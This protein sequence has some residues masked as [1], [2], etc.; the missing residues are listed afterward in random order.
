MTIL[1]FMQTLKHD[2]F[3]SL[4]KQK[5]Y[6][7]I[8]LFSEN[9]RAMCFFFT[10]GNKW[11]KVKYLGYNGKRAVVFQN[12][13]YYFT[14]KQKLNKCNCITSHGT[15]QFYSVA[16]FTGKNQFKLIHN[17]VKGVSARTYSINYFQPLTLE[18]W[19]ANLQQMPLN[20]CQQVPVPYKRLI[21]DKNETDKRTS[22]RQILLIIE[23]SKPTNEGG[24]RCTS[25]PANTIKA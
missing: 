4:I 13:D 25:F 14:D 20:R 15:A 19:Y 3:V 22:N 5:V 18:S 24:K 7:K 6:N 10:A 11:Y 9:L 21:Q 23:R 2:T 16:T 12:A 17:D 1:L 8:P